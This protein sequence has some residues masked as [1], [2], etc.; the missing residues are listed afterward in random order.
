MRS[1]ITSGYFAILQQ[2]L[3]RIEPIKV[4]FFSLYFRL[5]SWRL[6]AEVEEL[7]STNL[8]DAIET[9]VATGGNIRRFIDETINRVGP[10]LTETRGNLKLSALSGELIVIDINEGALINNAPVP[11]SKLPSFAFS[12]ISKEN[13]V[14]VQAACKAI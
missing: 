13:F 7:Y 5:N 2:C 11:L 1:K 8:D 12:F 6:N 3:Q 4:E 9:L 10:I 14:Q